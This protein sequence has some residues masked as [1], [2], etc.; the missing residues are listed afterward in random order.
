MLAG[1]TLSRRRLLAFAASLL[2]TAVVSLALASSASAELTFGSFA[3][4]G[5]ARAGWIEE[6]NSP[7]G[8]SEQESIGLFANGTSADDFSDAA[9]GSSPGWRGSAY[10]SAELR[11]QGLHG[12]RKRRVGPPVVRFSDGGKGELWPNSLSQASGRTSRSDANGPRGGPCG[13]RT[14]Q[15]YEQVVACH[16]GAEASAVE[17]INDSGWLDLG[18]FQILVDN[19]SFGGTAV[20]APPP[21]VLGESVDLDGAHR[22]GSRAL[23]GSGSKGTR[24]APACRAPLPVVT[25]VDSRRWS[26][27][28][29]VLARLGKRRQA[30]ASSGRLRGA[31]APGAPL[32]AHSFVL[33]PA[34]WRAAVATRRRAA[35]VQAATRRA[36]AASRG[37]AGPVHRDARAAAT[38]RV[39]S[40]ARSGRRSTPAQGL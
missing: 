17:V 7:P 33:R 28:A 27:A 4:Q 1:L 20:S 32:R 14:S 38:R 15:S 39:R 37:A 35:P 24:C 19:V 3:T 2:L 12:R 10:G 22:P 36:G 11:L 16:P 6:P 9:R 13:D 8:S 30:G 21:P 31:A 25:V 23:P 40:A 5:D 18:G 29:G 26:R 34:A